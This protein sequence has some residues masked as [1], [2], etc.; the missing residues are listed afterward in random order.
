M[1]SLFVMMRKDKDTRL[2][3]GIFAFLILL[4]IA[5]LVFALLHPAGLNN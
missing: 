4:G 2:L 1:S 3:A 5:A